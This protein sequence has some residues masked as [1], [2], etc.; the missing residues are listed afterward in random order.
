[1]FLSNKYT[2]LYFKIISSP[3]DLGYTEN[4]HIIPK[5]MNGSDDQ[6][7]IV[8]ISARK[9]F[10][11]HYLLTKM[12]KFKS[13]EFFKLIKA[14][15]MMKSSSNNQERYINSKLYEKYK[16]YLS[17]SMSICQKGKNNS[18]YGT[19]WIYCPMTLVSKKIKKYDLPIYL[20]N[21]CVKGRIQNIN[22]FTLKNKINSKNKKLSNKNIEKE[23]YYYDLFKKY[24]L[25]EMSYDD[26][27][28][29][30]N[31]NCTASNLCHIFRRR[32]FKT[33]LKL[34]E[35]VPEIESR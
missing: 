12:V 27:I 33:K 26:F 6:S 35:A 29:D 2:K 15:S 18:Q 3:S 7:N 8:S 19:I 32:N 5:C 4:H 31:L 14:F 13:Q 16:K 21:G 10:L 1:M 30:N 9:H 11:C 23:R 25:S 17:I 28:K 34:M 24:M 20:N 22:N